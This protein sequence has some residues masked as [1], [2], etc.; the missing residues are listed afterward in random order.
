M[1][2]RS[3][4]QINR[5]FRPIEQ[6]FRICV[7]LSTACIASVT[8]SFIYYNSYRTSCESSLII[9]PSRKNKTD[10]TVPEL[11]IMQQNKSSLQAKAE[12]IIRLVNKLLR[13]LHRIFMYAVLGIPV[14]TVA[15]TAYALGGVSPTIENIVWDCCLWA[16]HELGPS[17]VKLA[18]WASTRPDLY[19]PALISRLESLQD[20]VKVNHSRA[21]TERTLRTTLGPNWKDFIELDDK[22]LGA[23]CVAQVY[24]GT[25]KD[26]VT[27]KKTPVAIKLIHPHVEAMIKTDMELLAMFANVCDWFPTLKLLALGETCREW[28]HSMRNQLDLRQEA[29]NLV[30]F[31]AKFSE[32]SWAA[33]PVPI[34][35]YVT[36]NV[37][38]E[39]LMEGISIVNYMKMVAEGDLAEEIE[40]LKMQLSDLGCRSVI[41]MVF[42]DNLIHGD[43]HPGEN[44]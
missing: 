13:Y 6:N 43:M 12:E 8:S 30:D 29:K 10:V 39:T 7:R 21:T 2:S 5:N 4:L 38:V 15:S 24:R 1:K 19:P 40:A 25:L 17:F 31:A 41:K 28:C 22:P 44:K 14:I 34:E 20:D 42:F 16:I 32:D 36:R 9:D 11:V 37:L 3:L 23:G 33:F 26:K 35:G 27:G 18:Q